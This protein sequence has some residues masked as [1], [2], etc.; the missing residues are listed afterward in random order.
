M[1]EASGDKKAA[2]LHELHII[3][4]DTLRQLWCSPLLSVPGDHAAVGNRDFHRTTALCFES[5]PNTLPKRLGE[6][7]R[8][9]THPKVGIGRSIYENSIYEK[10]WRM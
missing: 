9:L 1:F 2:S 8:R 7:Q 6:C 5:R 4:A 3:A 10:R